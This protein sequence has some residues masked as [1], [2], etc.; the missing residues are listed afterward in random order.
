VLTLDELDAGDAEAFVAATAASFIADLVESGVE[1][2]TAKAATDSLMESLLPAGVRTEG[3]QFRSINQAGR[4]LGRYWCGPV[5]DSPGDWFLFEIAID[6]GLRGHGV[7]RT[8]LEAV[9]SELDEAGVNRLGLNVFESN[10]AAI[11]LYRSLGFTAER[12]SSS[13]HEMWL[14]IAPS[15]S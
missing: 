7:G 14:T 11:A 4:R 5:H 15:R 3:H 10:T 2:E 12:T 1:A 8:A 13:S 9:I 6:E